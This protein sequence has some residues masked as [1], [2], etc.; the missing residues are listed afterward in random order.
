MQTQ[1]DRSLLSCVTSLVI[2]VVG[3]AGPLAADDKP[4]DKKDQK[5]AAET[6]TL[7]DRALPALP[8][9]TLA[10]VTLP[11]E[12]NSSLSLMLL[13]ATRQSDSSIGVELAPVGEVLRSHL[14]LGEGQGF[15]VIAVEGDSP[16]AKAGLQKNDVLITI[17]ND[18]IANVEGFHQSL[19]ASAEKPVTIGLIRSGKKQSV[20]VT[21]R[22]SATQHALA[23][24]ARQQVEEPKFWLGVGL[25][26]A[27]DTLRSQLSLAASEGLVVTN[28][29][30]D[31]P[32]A[33][34]GIMVND[35]LLKLQGKTLTTIEA[36]S[37]QLQTIADKTVPL[38]L[39][40]RGKP[41]T[42]SVTPQKRS[43]AWQTAELSLDTVAHQDVLFLA[44]QQLEVSFF[45]ALN[46]EP[47]KVKFTH[48][49]ADLEKQL[50]DLEAQIKQLETSLAAVRNSLNTPAQQDRGAEEKK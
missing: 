11:V 49:Q 3:I 45:E 40:R 12:S 5:P 42:L 23:W 33:K 26:A 38:E 34:A 1:I 4:A 18:A 27:D 24:L 17:G 6:V 21:P 32:A 25:T 37:K 14:G 46:T 9:G 13:A 50:S 15:V 19:A 20:E 35:L 43:S 2:F 29:D 47:V 48:A 30:A 41:A 10:P 36:L 28:V 7:G 16:A 44:P 31:S 22:D 8:E 39:L